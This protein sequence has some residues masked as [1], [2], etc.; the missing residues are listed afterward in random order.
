VAHAVPGG[1]R[2]NGAGALAGLWLHDYALL[3]IVMRAMA[4]NRHDP[5]RSS[6]RPPE[7]GLGRP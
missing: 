4:A 3:C 6:L 1:S 2:G 5:T 7:R